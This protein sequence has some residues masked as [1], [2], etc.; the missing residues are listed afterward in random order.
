[1]LGRFIRGSTITCTLINLM[2]WRRQTSL[3]SELISGA[4]AFIGGKEFQSDVTDNRWCCTNMTDLH[5]Y[6]YLC[7]R[8][9]L[10]AYECPDARSGT[11]NLHHYVQMFPKASNATMTVQRWYTSQSLIPTSWVQKSGICLTTAQKYVNVS[12]SGTADASPSLLYSIVQHH[13]ASWRYTGA[14]GRGASTLQLFLQN[15]FSRG[16]WWKPLL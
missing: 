10:T 6:L 3:S 13:H 9:F 4:K 5:N 11:L 16:H 15:Q 14:Y 1:M 12:F 8:L 7:W 2:Q